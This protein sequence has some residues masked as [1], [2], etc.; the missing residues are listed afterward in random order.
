M[1]LR[2]IRGHNPFVDSL[3]QALR[4]G[5]QARPPQIVAQANN[6]R[7]QLLAGHEH[8]I[9]QRPLSAQYITECSTLLREDG[10]RAEELLLTHWPVAVESPHG[11]PDDGPSDEAEPLPVQSLADQIRLPA[12]TRF[13][14]P[15]WFA[16]AAPSADVI[17]LPA[18]HQLG[19]SE[20]AP[21]DHDLKKE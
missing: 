14:Q 18:W 21:L 19:I 5:P 10:P 13:T 2:W 17:P 12:S 16:L 20:P 3:F 11:P 7:L 8:L 9:G 15:A 4:V 1:P 6:L